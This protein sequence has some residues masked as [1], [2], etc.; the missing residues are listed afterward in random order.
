MAEF[1]FD[2]CTATLLLPKRPAS[3]LVYAVMDAAEAVQVQS[4]LP[5][6]PIIAALTVRD[7]NRELSPWPAVAVFKGGDFPGGAPA[8]LRLLEQEIL[9]TCEAALP[10]PI[11][12]RMIAGYSLAGLFALW[13]CACG[14]P[15][16]A[17]A[18]VSGSLWFDGFSPWLEAHMADFRP[19]HVY[20]SLGDAES[21][22]RN[23]RMARVATCTSAVLGTLRRHGIQ[24]IFE[25]NPGGHFNHPEERMARAITWLTQAA[26]EI[27]PM[28]PIS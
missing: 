21:K 22:A 23:P 10:Y 20:L 12:H 3:I 24:A 17:V 6:A 14:A 11:T 27:P 4:M 28:L 5:E 13:A 9:P 7:W 8:F 15:F 1:A 26:Q 25:Q 2:T 18:S 19:S 16:D